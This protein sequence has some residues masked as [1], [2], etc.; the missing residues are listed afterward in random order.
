VSEA[1]TLRIRVNGALRVLRVAAAGTVR[2]P[3][4][5]RL[6][7]LVVTARDAAGNESTLRR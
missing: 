5:E 2:I 4:I 3:R 6:R 1:A 7:T